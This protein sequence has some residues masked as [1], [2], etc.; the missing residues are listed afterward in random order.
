[1][2]AA[3]PRPGRRTLTILLLSPPPTNQLLLG[4]QDGFRR[5]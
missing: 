5:T 2:P 4:E 1:L 3:E